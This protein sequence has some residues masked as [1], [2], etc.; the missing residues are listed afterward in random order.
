MGLDVGITITLPDTT[1]VDL[2]DLTE[3]LT[4]TL[5]DTLGSTNGR[6]CLP[7]VTRGDTPQEIDV[8]VRI[9]QWGQ[10]LEESGHQVGDL[11]RVLIRAVI[12]RY[13]PEEGLTIVSW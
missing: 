4:D 12:D 6:Y 3:Y 1:V 7:L 8:S 9:C 5:I 13:D 2:P 10:P 11:L